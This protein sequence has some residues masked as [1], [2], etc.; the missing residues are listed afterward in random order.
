MK[1]KLLSILDQ[2]ENTV[3]IIAFLE[4][5]LEYSRTYFK[6]LEQLQIIRWKATP[7]LNYT[8]QKTFLGFAT[9]NSL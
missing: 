2:F 4:L 7:E 9:P 3:D 8:M 5:R 6:I 1:L